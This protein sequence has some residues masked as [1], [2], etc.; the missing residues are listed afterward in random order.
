M[1][2]FLPLASLFVSSLLLAQ[3]HPVEILSEKSNSGYVLKAKN[4]AKTQHE[5]VLT[6]NVENMKG[7]KKPIKK[8]VPANSTVEVVKLSF[9]KGKVSRYSANFSYVS[10]PTAKEI[11]YKKKL[12]KAKES[13]EISDLSKGIVVFSKDGCTRCHYVTSYLLDNEIDFIFLNTSENRRYNALMWDL[14]RQKK[15]GFTA[16]S[17][18]MPVVLIDGEMSYNMTDL[19]AFVKSLEN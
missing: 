3:A 15:P 18:T 13:E 9:I 5:I 4:T 2:R 12:L 19:K 16:N 6:L 10:K 11:A 7:Y 14:V 8:L 1:K 17:V